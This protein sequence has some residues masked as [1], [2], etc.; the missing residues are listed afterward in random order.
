MIRLAE[1]TK[2]LPPLSVGDLVRI[3]NQTGPSPLKWDKT[4]TVV[5][6]RQFDQYVVRVDGTGRVTLRNRI[7]LRK[8]TPVYPLPPNKI[9]ALT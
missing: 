4:G 5:E 9:L 1:H 7:F 8:Y 6:V 3:Q 2:R